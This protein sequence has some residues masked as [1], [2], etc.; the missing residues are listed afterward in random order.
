M[1]DTYP[2]YLKGPHIESFSRLDFS[3][4]CD[5]VEVV[6]AKFIAQQT[7]GQ[8]GGKNRNGQLLENI[9]KGPDM[10]FMGVCKN[11]PKQSLLLFDDVTYVGNDQVDSQEVRP[12]EHQAAVDS[13]RSAFI[14]QQHHIESELAQS[15]ERDHP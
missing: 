9:R 7:E 13:D 2:F 11:D 15:A 3:K 10:V 6:L 8:P 4:I 5:F 1:S 14:F 12:R